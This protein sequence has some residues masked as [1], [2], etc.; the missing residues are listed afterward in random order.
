MRAAMV[1][2]FEPLPDAAR[3]LRRAVQRNGFRNVD[4]SRLGIGVADREGR[5]RLVMSARGGFGATSLA[6]DAAGEI[7]LAPLDALHSAPVDF[8]KIDVE[9]LEMSVLGGAAGLIARWRP[10]IFIEV[11]NRNV[12][13]FSTWL[14]ATGYEVARIFTDK[15]HANYLLVPGA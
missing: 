3:P 1:T 8:L 4:L 10:R 2:P 12:A 9:G 13:A 7:V 6:A 14:Y 15:G 11:A 5:A